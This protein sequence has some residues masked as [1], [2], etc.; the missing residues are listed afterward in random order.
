MVCSATI[1]CRQILRHAGRLSFRAAD[2]LAQQFL[3]LLGLARSDGRGDGI[4]MVVDERFQASDQ[5][6]P[7]SLK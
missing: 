6:E 5:F 7:R 4:M 3:E 1:A 2:E